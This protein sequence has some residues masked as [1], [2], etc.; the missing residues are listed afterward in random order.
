M[1]THVSKGRIWGVETVSLPDVRAK[2][3]EAAG[4]LFG[5]PIA[6][7]ERAFQALEVVTRKGRTPLAV[8]VWAQLA[9]CMPAVNLL[10]ETLGLAFEGISKPW[11]KQPR[12][13]YLPLF[14]ASEV[15]RQVDWTRTLRAVL[16]VEDVVTRETTATEAA[17]RVSTSGLVSTREL[18]TGV[19]ESGR[20][21]RAYRRRHTNL[22]FRAL[23][24]AGGFEKPKL[25]SSDL[26]EF[27]RKAIAAFDQIY[28]TD[29]SAGDQQF[30]LYHDGRRARLAPFGM[31]GAYQLEEAPLP[32][33]SLWI[34][35]GNMI[36]PATRF[37][38]EAVVY[39]EDLINRGAREADFQQ[40][41]EEHPEFLLAFGDYVRLHPQVVLAEDG[42][43]RLIPD[44][45]L[46]KMNSD[47]CDICDLKLP[48]TELVR[49]QRNRTRFRDTIME[50]VAQLTYYRDW[51]EE[52]DR[53]AAF[54]RRYGLR[55]Y[56]PRV[57]VVIGRRESFYDDIER[58][59]LES[60]LPG[61]VS[62]KTYDD[63]VDGARRWRQLMLDG[64]SA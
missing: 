63:V 56:R 12:S 34:A 41:F 38:E 28:F 31:F 10:Y 37:S 18:A 17:R 54:N 58:I 33:G 19:F 30:V 7:E 14:P 42:G 8:H 53:R 64:G 39:L 49:R 6:F 22:V 44:F 1:V 47:F 50:A 25:W 62:L 52:R 61:W 60:Q 16:F 26:D 5:R 3:C 27:A 36:Q 35:R 23:A 55:A 48:T 43:E 45:F 15:V 51:F 59:S 29:P 57:V 24:R 13:V 11:P 9:R 46:E 2:I 40:F 32:D 20:I 21:S 4:V